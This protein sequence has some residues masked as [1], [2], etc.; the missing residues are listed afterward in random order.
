MRRQFSAS[1]EFNKFWLVFVIVLLIIIGCF[2]YLYSLY[3]DTLENKT[4]GDPSD[5]EELAIENT[6]I[7]EIDSVERYHGD[8]VYYVIDGSNE[9]GT[10]QFV[11]MHRPE[12]E[13]WQFQSFDKE[14]FH[15]KDTLLSEWSDRCDGCEYLGDTIGID[16]ETPILEIKFFN[17]SQQLVYEN[18]VLEDKSYNRLTLDPTF[19]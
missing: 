10:E 4:E 19:N 7:A 13:D 18:V 8:Y 2:I 17:P 14:P 15:S 1:I 5:I 6:D 9:E 3:Q 16:E 12:E 11:F